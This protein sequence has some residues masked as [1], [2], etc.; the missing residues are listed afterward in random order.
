MSCLSGAISHRGH[1]TRRS[2]RANE[3]SS[4]FDQRHSCLR[5]SRAAAR[6]AGYGGMHTGCRT[7][8]AYMNAKMSRDVWAACVDDDQS[9]LSQCPACATVGLISWMTVRDGPS[10]KRLGRSASRPRAPRRRNNTYVSVPSH[11]SMLAQHITLGLPADAKAGRRRRSSSWLMLWAIWRALSCS[12]GATSD[13]GGRAQDCRHH[14]EVRKKF[15]P[16]IGRT[17]R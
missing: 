12:H 17:Y 16:M 7:A 10:P 14:F 3:W 6:H 15:R 4:T 5:G 9:H 1:P 8:Y 13:S 11:E 2:W